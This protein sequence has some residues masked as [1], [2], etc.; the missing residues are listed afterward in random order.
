MLQG[1]GASM[2]YELFE[3]LNASGAPPSRGH[4]LMN[5]RY[6]AVREPVPSWRDALVSREGQGRLAEN[7]SPLPRAWIAG[8]WEV[9]PDWKAAFHRSL[10][11]RFPYRRAVVLDRAP[12]ARPPARLEGAAARIVRRESGEI[13]VESRTP[14]PAV[15]VMSELHYPGWS[16]EVDGR[17]R[18]LLRADGILRAVEVPAG[19]HRVTMSYRPTNWT[20]ALALALAGLVALAG[21]C[22]YGWRAARRPR[23]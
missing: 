20:L 12:A 8:G 22:A 4:D 17:E 13:E 11:E 23:P 6:A 19:V 10:D 1:Q 5:V 3:L 15:L 18:R 21:A 14:A 2:T 16:V 7:P 9:V